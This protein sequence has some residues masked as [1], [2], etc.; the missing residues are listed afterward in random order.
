MQ[1]EASD[2]YA[3]ALT[4]SEID[5]FGHNALFSSEIAAAF[6]A[7]GLTLRVVD[8]TR[9]T[10]AVFAALQDPA[11]AFFLCFNGFGSELR[12]PTSSSS[13][14]MPA[15]TA[16]NKL[17]FD[18]MHDCPAHETMSH[19]LGSTF[20]QR[21]LLVTDYGYAMMATELGMP[22]VV[23]VPSITFPSKIKNLVPMQDRDIDVLLPIGLTPPKL[24]SERH[25]AASSYRSG[26]FQ[27]VFDQVTERAV[28]DLRVDAMAELMKACGEAGLQ[29][30]LD[31]ADAR[32][33][34]TTV[35]DYVKFER[36]RRLLRTISHM[37][38]TVM[39]DQ[40]VEQ[41]FEGSRLNFVSARSLDEVLQ[42]M[43]R[44]RVV[45][46]PTPHVTGHHERVLGAFSRGAAVL[47]APNRVLEDGFVHWRDLVF[48]QQESEVAGL[49]EQLLG[50]P[51]TLAAIAAQGQDKAMRMFPPARLVDTIQSLFHLRSSSRGDRFKGWRS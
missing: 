35:L 12:V 14:L 24:V 28:E 19:Q 18:L 3:V 43:G 5:R 7:V 42:L 6:A 21:N 8:Y 16:F 44:C 30:R 13:R 11:C 46:C 1:V 22:N 50:A 29:L 20:P 45:L 51:E 26:V 31:Q 36:R 41:D 32:F 17:L 25:F 37:P 38:V 9:E 15:Y 33:L 23:H 48:F 2:S 49:I 47:S 34:I 39:A 10:R 4:R 27:A 40:T